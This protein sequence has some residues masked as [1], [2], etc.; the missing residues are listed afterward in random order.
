[1]YL[2]LYQGFLWFHTDINKWTTKIKKQYLIDLNTLQMEVLV[3]ESLAGFLEVLLEPLLVT[4]L[5]VD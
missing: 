2:E 1:M 4:L 3:V 5:V